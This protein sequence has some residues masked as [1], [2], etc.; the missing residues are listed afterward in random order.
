MSPA[1]W[2]NSDAQPTHLHNT[3]EFWCGVLLCPH[4]DGGIGRVETQGCCEEPLD[5]PCPTLH[6]IANCTSPRRRQGIWLQSFPSDSHQEL[7]SPPWFHCHTRRTKEFIL[8]SDG[9]QEVFRHVCRASRTFPKAVFPVRALPIAQMQPCARFATLGLTS[10]VCCT[11]HSARFA[12]FDVSSRAPRL[13]TMAK[14][15]AIPH[16]FDLERIHPWKIRLAVDASPPRDASA[17][18]S[19]SSCFSVGRLFH[20]APHSYGPSRFPY[21]AEG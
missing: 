6:R 8:F 20:V 4:G 13:S 9:V 3:K 5:A 17:Y 21:I 10:V 7:P 19:S 11:C 18:S 14:A 15:C 12:T 1:T 16:S 2:S